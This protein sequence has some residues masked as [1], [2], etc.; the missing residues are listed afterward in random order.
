MRDG[1]PGTADISTSGPSTSGFRDMK[2]Q[3][4]EH[5]C[6]SVFICL[7]VLVNIRCKCDDRIYE[8]LFLP[9]V[10]ATELEQNKI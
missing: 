4:A 8:H 3:S 6:Y 10:C 1:F 5:K 2:D 9:T 7:F